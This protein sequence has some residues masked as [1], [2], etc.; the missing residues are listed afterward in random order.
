M[1]KLG[2]V[3]AGGMRGFESFLLQPA[4]SSVAPTRNNVREC[5]MVDL[6]MFVGYACVTTKYTT[7]IADFFLHIDV[8]G[9]VWD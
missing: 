2:G 7:G 1:V 9:I 5:F 8:G 3:L 4:M 6:K